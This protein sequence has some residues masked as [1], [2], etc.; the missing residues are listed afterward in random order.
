[1]AC[2]LKSFLMPLLKDLLLS[3]KTFIQ[4]VAVAA[5]VLSI[6]SYSPVVAI[7]LGTFILRMAFALFSVQVKMACTL[8]SFLVPLLKDLL[9]SL[10][11]FIQ[12]I[13]AAALVLSIS[14]YS[15][16]VAIALGT[17]ILRRAFALFSVE[18]KMACTLKSFLVP[19]LKDLLLSLKTFIQTVAVAALLRHHWR[20]SGC[21]T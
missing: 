17:F 9:L 6:S 11:T 16:V 4:T 7:A 13:A 12:T 5:Q 21:P 19:L 18:V 2:T 8:K 1:M 15:A 3:L 10:K 14:S 20:G